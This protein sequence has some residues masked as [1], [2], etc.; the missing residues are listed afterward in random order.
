[1]EV[2][3][4]VYLFLTRYSDYDATCRE[5]ALLSINS[6]QKDLGASTALVR[7]L[8]LRVMS[9]IRVPEIVQIQLLAVKKCASDSS[10]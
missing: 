10:P 9:S 8:A 7:A 6:F 2:K 5:L 3:K 4:M 1:V